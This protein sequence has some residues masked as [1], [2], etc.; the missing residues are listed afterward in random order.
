MLLDSFRNGTSSFESGIEVSRASRVRF[1]AGVAPILL[2]PATV[3]FSLTSSAR[4]TAAAYSSGLSTVTRV[5]PL[6]P[7]R[8]RPLTVIVLLP[9]A[10]RA[11][12][13]VEL[14]ED[15][16]VVLLTILTYFAAAAGVVLIL[17]LRPLPAALYR[18]I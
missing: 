13:V 15:P 8:T 16:V 3:I 6:R 4:N 2:D 1:V 17:A 11:E 9:A 7:P 12:N 14:L 10:R 5:L 18:M